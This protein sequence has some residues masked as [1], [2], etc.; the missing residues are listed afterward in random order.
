MQVSRKLAAA[1]PAV[2]LTAL[3]LMSSWGLSRGNAQL[4]SATSGEAAENV[5]AKKKAE[6]G[7]K[8]NATK[9]VGESTDE[10][11]V[12]REAVNASRY[13]YTYDNTVEK[14][15]GRGSSAR[16]TKGAIATIDLQA[17]ANQKHS[18]PLG[19]GMPGNT[20]AELPQGERTFGGVKFRIGDG[21]IQL[22]GK[23]LPGRPAKIEGI[24]VGRTF[25]VLH[26]LHATC[27]G[28]AGAP[29]DDMFVED[30]TLV[31]QYQ[32]GYEDNLVE[33][34]PIVY[35]Q[36]VRDWWNWDGSKPAGRAEV[37][38]TGVNDLA[39][40]NEREIR[41]YRTAWKNPRPDK[42]VRQIDFVS[43]NDSAA[44]PFCVAMTAAGAGEPAKRAVSVSR[45]ISAG[46]AGEE[47]STDSVE[48]AANS[49]GTSR[50]RRR[51]PKKAPDKADEP[52]SESFR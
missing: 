34:I 50:S 28:A 47:G 42:V 10:I 2:L 16:S 31:G 5:D 52:A 22:A 41:L 24:P 11:D 14:K 45:G 1:V 29:G 43:T 37:A 36:D 38:W 27:W 7:A 46:L 26:V 49:L 23:L 8:K 3:L 21:C 15:D 4:A 25:Q 20:L 18:E 44:A 12:T 32:V 33:T 9:D 35:G 19:S 17:R 40:Q 39:R 51:L 13:Y 48:P 6:K 30:G